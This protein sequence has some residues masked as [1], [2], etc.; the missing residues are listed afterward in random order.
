MFILQV[1]VKIVGAAKVLCRDRRD[2]V[3]RG[4]AISHYSWTHLLKENGTY[5]L[6]YFAR[7]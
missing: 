2:T 7:L 4:L 3:L 5:K 6:S 1:K